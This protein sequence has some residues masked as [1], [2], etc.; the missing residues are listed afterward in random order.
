LVYKNEKKLIK[1][2]EKIIKKYETV[3]GGMQGLR[4]RSIRSH[5]RA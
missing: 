1:K 5:S 4:G 3:G 2:N